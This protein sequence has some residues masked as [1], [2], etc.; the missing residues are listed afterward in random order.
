MKN[1]FGK[2]SAKM[3]ASYSFGMG[4][5]DMKKIYVD[6]INN[7]GDKSLPGPGKYEADKAF[8]AKGLSY[9]MHSRLPTDQQALDRSKKLPGP[10]SYQQNDLCGKALN[11]SVFVN[12]KNFSVGKTTRFA[13]PT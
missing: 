6:H 1:T 12:A 13:V 5:D 11:N 2:E 4:R 10:G 8:G 7:E 9:Y 3:N